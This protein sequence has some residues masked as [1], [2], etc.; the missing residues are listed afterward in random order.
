M[1]WGLQCL[2]NSGALFPKDFGQ[3]RV[4]Q[5]V[6]RSNVGA[7]QDWLGGGD[8]LMRLAGPVS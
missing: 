4:L 3:K 6:R 5:S 1:D 8:F 7:G 2:T